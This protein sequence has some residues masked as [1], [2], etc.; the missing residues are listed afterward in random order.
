MGKYRFKCNSNLLCAPVTKQFLSN[1]FISTQKNIKPQINMQIPN[2]WI[3]KDVTGFREI[4]LWEG[5]ENN[6]SISL[7]GN[8][9]SEL[10]EKDITKQGSQQ[11]VKL[12]QMITS[13]DKGI[14][15]KY[16]ITNV[17]TYPEFNERIYLCY[18]YGK[19]VDPLKELSFDQEIPLEYH[20][21]CEILSGQMDK[22]KWESLSI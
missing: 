14:I 5:T 13:A 16:E 20:V 2:Y 22:E 15:D 21:Y 8:G 18:K 6:I 17:R 12:K 4:S 1:S 10:I 7:L 3:H 11:N 19:N 9:E